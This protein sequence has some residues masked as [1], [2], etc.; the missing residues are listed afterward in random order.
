[1]SPIVLEGTWEEIVGRADEL[2][3]KRVRLTVIEEIPRT[4][5]A[6]ESI[7]ELA[8]RLMADVPDEEL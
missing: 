1:M 6:G 3:G 8:A 7:Y 2:A 5:P 4:E